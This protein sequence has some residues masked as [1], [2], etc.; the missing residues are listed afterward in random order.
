[1]KLKY[2]IP[3]GSQPKQAIPLVLPSTPK[4]SSPCGCGCSE[5]RTILSENSIHYASWRC[6]E[7]DRFRGWIPK[8]TSLTAQQTS[9]E[10]ID[11]LLA[12][13]K[14]NDWE[15]GFCQ[16]LKSQRKYSPRQKEK[17]RA[18]AN[19]LGQGQGQEQIAGAASAH[20]LQKKG[21]ER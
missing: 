21:G 17:L 16:S 1:M 18:I 9:D 4:P 20:L 15:L 19:R 3:Q 10:L 14:L 5:V 7:C 8:P 13:G 12:S 6:V 2:I 11:K